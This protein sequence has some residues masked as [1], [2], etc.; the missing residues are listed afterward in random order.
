MAI[1]IRSSLHALQVIQKLIE[2]VAPERLTFLDIFRGNVY[3]LASNPYSCRVLQ[4]CLEHL[5]DDQARPLLDELHK[6]SMNL[7]QDQYGVSIRDAI[8]SRTRV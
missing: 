3:N 2:Q 5:P 7:M 6:Y 4:R 8:L 1:C